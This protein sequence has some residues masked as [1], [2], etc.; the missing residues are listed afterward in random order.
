MGDDIEDAVW[1]EGD[2]KEAVW[3]FDTADSWAKESAFCTSGDAA[4][5]LGSS[6]GV[7]YPSSS[8]EAVD[9]DAARS[10]AGAESS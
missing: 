10:A 3:A 5:P 1:V 2:V 6:S 7:P 4:K 8:S 9:D